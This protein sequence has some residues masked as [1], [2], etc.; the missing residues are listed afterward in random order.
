MTIVRMYSEP[1]PRILAVDDS[2]AILDDFRRIVPRTAASPDRLD[3]QL[4]TA[5]QGQEAVA[6]AVE[7]RDDGR[8]YAVA[9]VDM[10]MPPGWDG[11]QTI[12]RLWEV[13]PALQIVICSAFPDYLWEDL[14]ARLGVRD[15]L[16]VIKKPFDPIEVVQCMHALTS[17]WRLAR[18]A[19]T[20]LHQVESELRLAHKLE[21]IGQLASGIAHE[22]NTPVQYVG[23]SLAF[24]REGVTGMSQL[25]AQMRAAI[26]DQPALARRFDALVETADFPYFDEHMP[27]ALTRMGDGIGRVGT[28][29]RSMKELAH[30][31]PRER[32]AVDINRAVDNALQVT[33]N[34]YKYFADVV[35]D[36][37][38]LPMVQG[39]Q[40]DLGQVFVNLIVNAGH[41]ME[42]RVK[43]TRG[44]GT[45]G[46]RTRVD[47]DHVV[48]SIADTGTGIAEA[49]RPF[50][51]DAFYT[52]KSVG[53]GTGQGLAITSRIVVE[54]H[55]GQLTFETAPGVGT[56]FHVRLPIAGP[57][58]G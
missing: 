22:I 5:F 33:A 35:T 49:I 18:A 38:P 37:Q 25:I 48:I 10:H 3:F 31:G 11:L 7:A 19:A 6:R 36:L 24:V 23:D 54:G 51:F 53:R 50:V 1:H 12:E 43:V 4:D 14:C 55:G 29:V 56:T 28:I 44:R 45:L 40:S 9:F 47:G 32:A 16:L 46:V 8:P 2:R 39:F 20:H 15:D 52:T 13:D 17:K 30:N 27:E 42:D 34:G 26:A 21:A 41:A 58:A 57:R